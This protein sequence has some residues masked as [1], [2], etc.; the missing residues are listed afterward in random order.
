MLSEGTAV[1]CGECPDGL[2]CGLA[3]ARFPSGEELFTRN[4]GEFTLPSER[5]FSALR[6]VTQTS[7]NYDTLIERCARATLAEESDQGEPYPE[8]SL[9][10]A[11]VAAVRSRS[12]VAV[13]GGADRP[14]FW[15]TKLHGS[16]HWAWPERADPTDTV[17]EEL[18]PS[19]PP[20]EWETSYAPGE[21]AFRL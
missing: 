3:V 16:L 7:L 20:N 13:L 6:S 21:R 17:Y 5:S 1:L 10:V 9:Y 8:T 18:L 19:W 12:G 4:T 11:P 2:R 14:T 15:L